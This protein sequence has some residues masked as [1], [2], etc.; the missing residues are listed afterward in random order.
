MTAVDTGTPAGPDLRRLE[1]KT[2]GRVELSIDG[3]PPT[4]PMRY[5][6]S[7]T[8]RELLCL[9]EASR[10]GLPAD[11]IIDRLWPDAP[12]EHRR[13]RLAKHV[14]RLRSVLG[15]GDGAVGRRL[16]LSEGEVRR[17][18]PAV[19]IATDA[20]RFEATATRALAERDASAM[21]ANGR[22]AAGDARA[23]ADRR[24]KTDALAAADA[25]YTGPYMVEH[26]AAWT[27][28]RRRRLAR[29]QADV[30]RARVEILLAGPCPAEAIE[31]AER[32]LRSNPLSERACRL[33]VSTLVATG[34][35]DRARQVYR[36]FARR[37]EREI[38]V[39]PGPELARAARLPT[40][41]W[42]ARAAG[43]PARER[44]GSARG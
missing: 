6:R 36:A 34:D 23:A 5:W 25:L 18:H 38:G 17:L 39:E 22:P 20:D 10:S 3:R 19:T 14:H 11:A 30:L 7:G 37:L 21:A 2:L 15:D 12:P 26:P 16:L 33:L 28:P 1:L 29:L 24:A 35:V 27:L 31:P 41:G 32:L 40:G 4:D 13:Q 9:L 43:G 42:G 8:T 44:A